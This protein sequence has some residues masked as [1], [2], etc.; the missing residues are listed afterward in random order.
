M[1]NQ[2]Q[3]QLQLTI[4]N[5]S[6]KFNQIIKYSSIEDNYGEYYHL[7]CQQ[8]VTIDDD[9]KTYPGF[10]SKL[11]DLIFSKKKKKKKKNQDA[12][13]ITRRTPKTIAPKTK[14]LEQDSLTSITLH[15]CVYVTDSEFLACITTKYS[16]ITK[17]S[18]K[19]FPYET[20]VN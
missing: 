11:L 4:D 9:N 3:N 12:F 18:R 16:T 8:P 19:V 1:E 13:L 17:L 6:N 7:N 10:I 15:T 2:R 14:A 20:D 5:D